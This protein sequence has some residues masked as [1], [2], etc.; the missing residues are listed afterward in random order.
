MKS[1]CVFCGSNPGNDPVYAEGARAMG[2]EIC[3][4]CKPWRHMLTWRGDTHARK[5]QSE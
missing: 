2:A 4:G 1:V 5:S 3:D